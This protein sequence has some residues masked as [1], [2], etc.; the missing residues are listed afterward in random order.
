MQEFYSH[1]D[2][3]ELEKRLALTIAQWKKELSHNSDASPRSSHPIIIP[4]IIEPE[5]TMLIGWAK[6]EVIL[7]KFHYESTSRGFI[8]KCDYTI[9]RSRFFNTEFANLELLQWKLSNEKLVYLFYKL[10]A[11]CAIAHE[12]SLHTILPQHFLNRRRKSFSSKSIKA[13]LWIIRNGLPDRHI[14]SFLE[15]VFGK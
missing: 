5:Q 13:T 15:L 2:I 7:K 8:E 1:N 4:S 3:K 6:E 12:H 10:N 9:F 11:Y 14:D